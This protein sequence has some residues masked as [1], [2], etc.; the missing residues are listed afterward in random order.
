MGLL[1]YPR[2][3]SAQVVRYLSEALAGTG[4]KPVLAVGSLGG[5]GLQTNASTFFGRDDIAVV[6]YSAAV[7]EFERG[8]DPMLA[9]PPMHPSF[10]DRPHVPDR[11]FAGVSMAQAEQQLEAWMR[12]IEDPWREVNVCH[13]HHL[14]PI[15]DAVSRLWP[16]RPVVTHLHGTELKM[17]DL[18]AR[19]RQ[20]SLQLGTDLAGMA[21]RARAGALPGFEALEDDDRLVAEETRWTCWEFADHWVQRLAAAARRT[22]RFICISP[23]DRDLAVRLLGLAAQRFTVIPN[24][25]DTEIFLRR[26]PTLEER[27]SL[28][29]RWLVEQPLGWD[30]SGD[31][32]TVAYSEDV[33]DRFV[34]PSSGR[35][36]PVIL[37][38]GRFLGFKRVP[39]LVRA[40]GRASPRF[41]EPA[42]L[43]IWGGSSGEWEGEHP[44]SVA[45]EEGIDGVFF[46]GWRG[47]DELPLG[48]A[49]SAVLAAPSVDEPFGQ[50]F[51]EA[52]SCG[53]P[54]I[55]TATGGPLSFV[56][57]DAT[58]P[59]GWLVPPDDV[60]A[61]ADALVEAVNDEA[62]RGERAENACR[63]I[64]A[65]YAWSALAERFVDVYERALAGG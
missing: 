46:V 20:I 38:V 64:R 29:R 27:R 15:H 37:F 3:G 65:A 1:F 44:H 7:G 53:L 42:P 5:P 11:I 31:P 59:N 25:V 17:L 18:I 26:D 55:T 2:G 58:Q 36:A 61:L 62:A 57:T 24:G 8:N 49:C 60:D 52:M 39:L 43:V 47:H 6:D 19:L 35:A 10:E 28:W 33:L 9:V 34:G 32:G 45:V 23:H 63:Q 4:W 22:S 50:V 40:Y 48:L 16:D 41:E 51:L 13:L 21:R 30:E 12:V 56:N 54:V 14:T